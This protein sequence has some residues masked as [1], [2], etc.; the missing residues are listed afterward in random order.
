MKNHH[1]EFNE[2]EDPVKAAP[3]RGAVLL[4]DSKGF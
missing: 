4:P 3:L 2:L 1:Q